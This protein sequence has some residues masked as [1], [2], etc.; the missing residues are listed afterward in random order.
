MSIEIAFA[1]CSADLIYVP[2]DV[3]DL[4]KYAF[5]VHNK[6]TLK[7][8]Y[9]DITLASSLKVFEKV[10]GIVRI[11]KSRGSFKQALNQSV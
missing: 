6:I 2:L 3:Y 10:S 4:Q 5:Y 11:D 7:L 1:L 9:T 8:K